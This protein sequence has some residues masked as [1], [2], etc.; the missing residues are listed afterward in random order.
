MTNA[1]LPEV[2]TGKLIK[3][4]SANKVTSITN[5]PSVAN[6]ATIN[7]VAFIYGADANRVVQSVGT[8]LDGDTART[9]YVGMGGTGKSLYERTTH[10]TAVDHVHFLYAGGAHGGNAFALRVQTT[11]TDP[12]SNDNAPPV[13]RYQHV[14]HLGSVT[15]STDEN[16]RVVGA[17]GGA[18]TTVLGYDAW[19]TRRSPDGRPAATP[20]DLQPGHREFTGHETIP[21][22]GLVNMNGR[23]YDPELG[24]F[25]SPDPNVQL[26]A[27]LQSYNRYSYAANNPLRYT[28]P[29]GYGLFSFLTSSNFWV[30][31]GLGVLDAIACAGTGGAGCAPMLIMTTYYQT[32]TMLVS[33]VPFD[34]VAATTIVGFG[35]G[36]VGGAIGGAIAGG[37]GANPAYQIVGGAI[38]GAVSGG[39]TTLAFGGSLG[40]NMFLGAASGAASAAIAWSLNGTNPVSQASADAQ[41]GGDLS[42]RKGNFKFADWT[43]DDAYN[44]DPDV[45]ADRQAQIDLAV[46]T[47]GYYFLEGKMPTYDPGLGTEGLTLSDGTVTIGPKGFNS[48]GYLTSTV[49][50]ESV[51]AEQIRDYGGF[52]EA[53]ANVNEVQAYDR[54]LSSAK[55][56]GLTTDEIARI[57]G[58]RQP[59]YDNLTTWQKAS[60]WLGSY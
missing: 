6:A 50:H 37:L 14:D 44:H 45:M 22:L 1:S 43:S 56:N 15:A 57:Q 8:A 23:V 13:M 39:I 29:T 36:Y 19:G 26:L 5:T 42:A 58:Y 55:A 7:T 12:G 17:L 38:A 51:H 59:Y 54:E 2:G 32:S 34:Q 24:R 53:R 35:A 41:Q 48:E 33:G 21:S 11:T 27:D 31:F 28:D 3:Y 46:K 49:E 40:Q 60:V 9:V 25:L 10:G 20:L 18:A 30:G 47:H 52:S 4:N 16:D